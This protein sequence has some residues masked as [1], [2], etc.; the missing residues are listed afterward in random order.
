MKHIFL[1]ALVSLSIGTL[2]SHARAD[3]AMNCNVG[4]II[5]VVSNVDSKG[6]ALWGQHDVLVVNL[7]CDKDITLKLKT[8]SRLAQDMFLLS[9]QT[10]EPVRVEYD[11]DRTV[12]SW[13]GV[14]PTKSLFVEML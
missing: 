13:G 3:V 1:A 5:S 9:K 7:T 11:V 6:S 14:T 10:K 4:K 8:E 2:S 12:S